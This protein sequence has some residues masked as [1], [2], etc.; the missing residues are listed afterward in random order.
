M[1]TFNL[2]DFAFFMNLQEVGAKKR[3][4]SGDARRKE[5]KNGQEAVRTFVDPKGE[6]SNVK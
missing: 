4:V 1:I 6:L 2:T 5:G 3:G